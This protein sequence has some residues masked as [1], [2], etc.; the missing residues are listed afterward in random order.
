VLAA[1]SWPGNVRELRNI[2][3]RACL[4]CDGAMIEARHLIAV[5]P[6]RAL[7]GTDRL[8]AP[9]KSLKDTIAAAERE[10]IA[11]AL[12]AAGGNK[13]AAARMLGISRSHLYAKLGEPEG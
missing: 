3:E 6:V 4:E 1:Y 11:A 7:V 2:L 10:A 13:I 5:M 9:V 12:T 8:A